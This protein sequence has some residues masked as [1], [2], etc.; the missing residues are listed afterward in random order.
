MRV[1]VLVL[2]W[3]LALWWVP[4]SALNVWLS[5]GFAMFAVLLVL[6]LVRR[7][8]YWLPVGGLSGLGMAMGMILAELGV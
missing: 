6:P 4:H 2:S 3:L 5:G 7:H 1:A 8:W